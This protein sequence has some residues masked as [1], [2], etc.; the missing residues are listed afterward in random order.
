M[1][2]IFSAVSFLVHIR[3][4]TEARIENLITIINFYHKMCKDTQFIIIED[5]NKSTNVQERLKKEVNY[6][7]E[8]VQYY[9]HENGGIYQ[10]P[11][12]YNIASKKTDRE[13]IVSQDT[14]VIIKPEQLLFSA[15]KLI[16][17]PK[18][19]IMIPYNG[20]SF[21]VKEHVKKEFIESL[22]YNTLTKYIPNEKR[23]YFQDNNVLVGNTQ[24]VGGCVMFNHEAYKQF[25]GYNPNF[26]GWGYEDH[27]IINRATKMGFNIGRYNNKYA[28]L[29]HLPHHGP[30]S[31]K[32]DKDNPYYQR[33]AQLGQMV[34]N[35]T[36]EQVKNYQATWNDL[37]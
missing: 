24:S 35:M 20:L 33:N 34:K 16:N 10:R 1:K 14:D 3:K 18:L 23:V 27:E 19:G 25:G 13:I 11:L 28:F 15:G 8:D 6:D 4:D 22:N 5:D 32:K 17:T 21:F 29:W 26:I 37:L 30:G 36:Y 2:N 12:V 9:F 31:D 7:N